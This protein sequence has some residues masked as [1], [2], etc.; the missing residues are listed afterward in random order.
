MILNPSPRFDL[1]FCCPVHPNLWFGFPTPPMTYDKQNSRKRISFSD[2]LLTGE[3]A[4]ARIFCSTA[5]PTA[6]KN[7]SAGLMSSVIP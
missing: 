3:L 2:V 7:M 1:Q 6:F 4:T 5:A